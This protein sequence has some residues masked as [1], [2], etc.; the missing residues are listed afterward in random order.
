MWGPGKSE[1]YLAGRGIIE[2][3]TPFDRVNLAQAAFREGIFPISGAPEMAVA[4]PADRFFSDILVMTSWPASFSPQV[5]PVDVQ[6]FSDSP[7]QHGSLAVSILMAEGVR[8]E[9]LSEHDWNP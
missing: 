5:C 4:C 2:D 3:D 7:S 9:G 1:S 8:I 6:M